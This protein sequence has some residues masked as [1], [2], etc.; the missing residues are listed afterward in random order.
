MRKLSLI[1]FV[2]VMITNCSHHKTPDHMSKNEIQ[3]RFM[4][5]K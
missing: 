1:I 3:N 4:E 5:D 2:I